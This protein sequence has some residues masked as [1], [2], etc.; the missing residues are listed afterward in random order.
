MNQSEMFEPPSTAD[1]TMLEKLNEVEREL[2]FRHGVYTRLVGEGKMTQ[3]T[4]DKRILV[5]E[6]VRD[7][8]RRLLEQE[9]E[10]RAAAG[11]GIALDIS[12]AGGATDD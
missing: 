1:I 11:D 8:I 4:A 3:A 10:A 9:N 5:M 12:Q 6:A 7:D 2:G